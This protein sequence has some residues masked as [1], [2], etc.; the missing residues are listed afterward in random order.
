MRSDIAPRVATVGFVEL[1]NP[2]KPQGHWVAM[3]AS[4]D[5]K[6]VVIM[7]SFLAG[8]HDSPYEQFPFAEGVFGSRTN[9]P[10]DY[11]WRMPAEM[12]TTKQQLN[13]YRIQPYGQ[14]VKRFIKY[15]A[16]ARYGWESG[17]ADSIEF[18]TVLNRMQ[19]WSVRVYAHQ[20][21]QG[22]NDCAPMAL[23]F[24]QKL[25]ADEQ[26]DEC[27]CVVEVTTRRLT[28]QP[29]AATRRDSSSC[30]PVRDRNYPMN[31]FAKYSGYYEEWE[32]TD[33]EEE[34]EEEEE[35]DEQRVNTFWS[36][37]FRDVRIK[38]PPKRP[39]MSLV[40]RAKERM[41]GKGATASLLV[42]LSRVSSQDGKYMRYILGRILSTHPG[43]WL[44]VFCRYTC[45]Q[46]ALREALIARA[47]L[48]GSVTAVQATKGMASERLRSMQGGLA[49]SVVVMVMVPDEAADS[50]PSA[51]ATEI[52]AAF[53]CARDLVTHTTYCEWLT[54]AYARGSMSTCVSGSSDATPVGVEEAMLMMEHGSV[55]VL[56]LA[57]TQ[58][59]AAE[60]A[61]RVVGEARMSRVPGNQQMP[62]TENHVVFAVVVPNEACLN[63]S[64]SFLES[65][66][67]SSD[68]ESRTVMVTAGIDITSP[69]LVQPGWA[70]RSGDN[71]RH[72]IR[73]AHGAGH[74]KGPFSHFLNVDPCF[75]PTFVSHR[76]E[77]AE[78]AKAIQPHSRSIST[79]SRT[80][81]GLAH[82]PCDTVFG[83]AGGDRFLQ[84][85][86][87]PY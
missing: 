75:W 37:M 41:R 17:A 84:A 71:P 27:K 39:S 63:A 53:T 35:T 47:R 87:M 9:R 68:G 31:Y 32:R 11:Y 10:G 7:D 77:A 76:G 34:E 51:T 26:D 1:G 85:F 36:D 54:R 55:L 60:L 16:V 82:P 70:P 4:I 69:H 15:L 13:M 65:L 81:T 6:S 80:Y 19:D 61:A 42:P 58:F 46:T 18:T 8:H 33:E 24:I 25:V 43:Y 62:G 72:I 74:K 23:S 2:R 57:R 30:S 86:C 66:D 48:S 22:V 67:S 45:A 64:R 49:S 73:R 5:A 3:V 29:A 83:D 20:G 52:E 40:E 56:P 21:V 44:N 12:T 78:R 14:A 59:G 50:E 79:A 38:T 28:A